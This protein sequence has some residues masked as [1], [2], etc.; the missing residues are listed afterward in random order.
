M[1]ESEKPRDLNGNVDTD[2]DDDVFVAVV[3]DEGGG[4]SFFFGSD[5]PGAA[6]VTD[7]F[8]RASREL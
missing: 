3:D 2:D 7:C 6:K 4:T 8:G 1:T 5:S